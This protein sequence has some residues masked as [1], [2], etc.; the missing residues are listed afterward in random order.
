MENQ[1]QSSKTFEVDVPLHSIGFEIQDLSP[2]RVSGHLTVTEKCCQVSLS[3]PPNHHNTHTYKN[4]FY[5]GFFV[6]VF[7]K[8]GNLLVWFGTW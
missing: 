5:F 6:V 3:F 4:I 1:Q 2:Q 7:N 8:D